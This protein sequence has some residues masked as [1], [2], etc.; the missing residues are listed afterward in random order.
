LKVVDLTELLARS[1]AKRQPGGSAE[2]GTRSAAA[3]A[4]KLAAKT[5][6]RRRA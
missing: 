6:S 1:L 5:S 3:T 4:K 2:D